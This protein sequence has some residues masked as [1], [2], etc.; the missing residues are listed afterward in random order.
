MKGLDNAQSL[1]E[2]KIVGTL[3][4][5]LLRGETAMLKAGLCTKSQF[6]KGLT[7]LIERA[8][9]V[10]EGFH[11]VVS[12]PVNVENVNNLDDVIDT[13]CLQSPA[14]R[15]AKNEWTNLLCYKQGVYQP[16][17]KA[18]KVLGALDKEGQPCQTVFALGPVLERGRNLPDECGLPVGRNLAD[19]IDK[20]GH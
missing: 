16:K 18:N 19:F 15:I 20:T 2:V 4:N 13:E 11:K 3:L 8:V 14:F 1:P 5:P 12:H 17:M 7:T 10:I 9:F 6:D